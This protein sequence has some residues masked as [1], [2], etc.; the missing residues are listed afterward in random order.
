MFFNYVNN[1]C[2]YENK[3]FYVYFDFVCFD[4]LVLEFLQCKQNEYSVTFYFVLFVIDFELNFY[5]NNNCENVNK[6]LYELF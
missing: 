3:T 5:V 4:K 1:N 6:T 2:K